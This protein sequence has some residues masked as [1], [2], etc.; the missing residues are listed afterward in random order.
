MPTFVIRNGKLINKQC[1]PPLNE[2][3]GEGPYLVLDEMPS[4]RHM[5]TGAYHT[6]KAKFRHDTKASGCIEV[7]TDSSI[8]RPRKP[9]E[10]DRGKRREDIKRAIYDLRNGRS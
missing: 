9:I 3:F 4:T 10:L 5:A 1:A 2:R 6:S 7:G 8:T